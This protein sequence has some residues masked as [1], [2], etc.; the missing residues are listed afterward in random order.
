ME[1]NLRDHVLKNLPRCLAGMRATP[2]DLVEDRGA[3]SVAFALSFEPQGDV[4]EVLGYD[5]RDYNPDYNG[6]CEFIS[7]LTIAWLNANPTVVFDSDVHG[8]HGEM[9]SSAKIHGDGQ[10]KKFVCPSCGGSSFRLAVQLDYGDACN[11]LWD[12]EP[13]IAIQD[14]FCNIMVAGTCVSCGRAS[15]ILDMDL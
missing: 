14:Y 7:P 13:E 9:E 3:E 11:D 4:G 2:T 10:P 6:P 5:L 8:Y 15:R 1:Q 12:D